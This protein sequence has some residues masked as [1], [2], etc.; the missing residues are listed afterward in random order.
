VLLDVAEADHAKLHLS[1]LLR[2]QESGI[3]IQGW[4][5]QEASG[6]RGQEAGVRRNQEAGGIRRQ[7]LHPRRMSESAKSALLR[8]GLTVS[9]SRLERHASCAW[10]GMGDIH[11]FRDL[12]VWQKSMDLAVR[13]YRTAQGLPRAEQQVL[14]YQL[15]KSSVSMPSNVA[16][17]FARRSTAH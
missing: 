3:R 4:A 14:G 16:E 8:T 6:E 7:E 13:C 15:R 2:N 9:L 12:L 11:S 10:R 5:R 17:G 1:I